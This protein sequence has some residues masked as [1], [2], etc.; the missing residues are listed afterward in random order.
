MNNSLETFKRS[1]TTKEQLRQT[2]MSPNFKL[3]RSSSSDL[4]PKI[5]KI[6]KWASLIV[7]KSLLFSSNKQVDRGVISGYTGFIPKLQHRFAKSYL[8]RS[9]VLISSP[10]LD[11]SQTYR[12]DEARTLPREWQSSDVKIAKQYNVLYHE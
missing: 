5:K 10:S 11:L 12:V 9:V 8:N 7:H 3:Q 1:M 2:K 4:L 6:P